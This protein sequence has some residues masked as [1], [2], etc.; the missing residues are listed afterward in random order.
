MLNVPPPRLI[1]GLVLYLDYDG[2]LHPEGV[3]AQRGR[4]PYIAY[5]EGHTL[6]EHAPLLEAV[7]EPYPAVRIV[8]STSWV[9]A[10]K[11]LRRV[12]K[13]LTPQLQARVIGAT[14]HT[15]IDPTLFAQAARGMQ[16][17]SDVLRRRPADWLAIDDD[18]F[19]WPAW[20]KDKLVVTDAILG[21]S[22]PAVLEELCAKLEKMAVRGDG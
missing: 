1:G 11:S 16:I 5:P 8:L 17:W 13:R 15:Q 20:C 21:I 18:Y 6:F 2:V 10:Y 9:R 12:A 7:L 22:A 3:Y 4:G 19:G 14:Y